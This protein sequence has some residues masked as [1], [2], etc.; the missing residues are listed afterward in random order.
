MSRLVLI[1]LMTFLAH[2][3][4]A[5]MDSVLLDDVTIV[6]QEWRGYATGV[7]LRSLT[8]D[9]LSANQSMADLLQSN[10]L[11]YLKVY[12]NG[13]LATLNIRGTGASQNAIFW[14]GINANVTSLGQS[15]FSLTPIAL[16]D[17]VNLQ[18]G[19]GSSLLGSD[20]IGGSVH[21]SSE[22]REDNQLV[23]GLSQGSFGLLGGNVKGRFHSGRWSGAT[24][25]FDQRATNNFTYKNTS[26]VGTPE[27][28]MEHAAFKQWGAAQ[29]FWYQINKRH[30]IS[31]H[32]W[33]Q[34]M[35]REI[36]P[37][38]GVTQKD[39]QEDITTRALLQWSAD[40]NQHKGT[41]K[42]ARLQDRIDF[43][44]DASVMPRTYVSYEHEYF[45]S[46]NWSV[47][48]GA[49]WQ[50]L[51]AEIDAY[52]EDISENRN[53]IFIS[54]NWHPSNR[55]EVTG[56]L[57][58]SFVPGFDPPLT[59]SLGWSY[60]VADWLKWNGNLSRS[61]RVP[62][63]NDRYW[64][65]GGNI[66][67]RPESGHHA[68]TGFEIKHNSLMHQVSTYYGQVEQ[69]I[70]WLPQEGFWAPENIDEVE[71]YGL[72][73]EGQ[74]AINSNL[75]L[76]LSYALNHSIRLSG[77]SDSFVGRQLPYVPKHQIKSQLS[78]DF[79]WLSIGLNTQWVSRR[80]TNA[81]N[82]QELDPFLLIGVNATVKTGDKWQFAISTENITGTQY[83]L[84]QNRA[85]PGFN[86]Q[87]T[88][89]HTFDLNSKP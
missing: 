69:W 43:N 54:L 32:L 49:N 27:I 83:Q 25:I 17:N 70:I 23:V 61:Y 75:I 50:I 74:W 7:K 62:T 36:Q 19:A 1:A 34:R 37:G 9:S 55:W 89:Q 85:M 2:L 84:M 31:G 10:A 72:E 71:I 44:S 88:I 28:E 56:N 38:I 14:H 6:G 13:Q 64:R 29:D 59:P 53:D 15:D 60:L 47:R 35:N 57:R 42:V 79:Q 58:Q 63:L 5:Q 86:Y 76:D 39:N 78:Y 21:I 3:G 11:A 77:V 67:L 80:F 12:G 16:V 40:Y 26:V 46:R 30:Q 33:Y 81:D 18:Y 65:P 66:N 48:G 24:R 82:S 68:E 45:G 52:Q 51:S 73:Y 8:P 41:L 20:V 22:R 87:F 4:T